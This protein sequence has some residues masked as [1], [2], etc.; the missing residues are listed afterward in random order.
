[1]INAESLNIRAA[2]RF[3]SHFVR[4]RYDGYSFAQ[5]PQTIRRLLIGAPEPGVPFGPR[6]DLDQPYDAVILLLIDAFGW[7][8]FERF[9]DHPF[10]RRIADAGLIS[11]LSSQF[12][13][14]TA[15]HVTTI[16][17]GQSV[18]QSGVYEWFYYEP[19][20]DD[21]IA[22]LLFSFA[23]DEQRDTLRT[24]GID[25]Q[26]LYP[27]R[28]LYHDLREHGVESYVFSNAL[29]ARSAYSQT[30]T[31]G[32]TIV[33][34]RTLPEALVNLTQMRARQHARSYYFLYYDAIDTICHQYG[35]DSPQLSAEVETFLDMMERV[36]Q[37]QLAATR[38]RTL[39]LLTADH[40]Q[41]A[42]DPA[43]TVYLNQI[44]P[45]WS[46]Y[47]KMSRA[48]KPL[49]PAGSSRDMFLHI[50]AANVDEAQ[51]HLQRLLLGKA[52]VMRVADL[53][54]QGF[55]GSISQ[56]FR[57]RVGDLVILP[58][59]RESVWWYEKD[60]FDQHF[61]GSHGGLTP[62]EMDTLLLV[63]PYG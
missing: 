53:I 50:H 17:T 52:D 62:D 2:D 43:T 9:A 40:G 60:R 1:M 10:L 46:R 33:A 49:V 12:P 32:A 59:A 18:G 29:Y 6:G 8:F 26:A 7:R 5:I 45:E 24:T 57:D 37:R 3:G 39:L 35:P 51:A 16:H 61:Y 42:I 25:P 48:G 41:T 54:E 28:T 15:A 31:A 21:L 58:Y 30:V 63:Q 38:G 19:Q 20:V 4:P 13:S 56:R 36:F 34:Y 44:W 55:F 27:T 47:V 22:P 23:G 11:K 14:T